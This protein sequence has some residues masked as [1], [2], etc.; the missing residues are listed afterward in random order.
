MAITFV[1]SN[2]QDSAGALSLTFTIPAGATTDDFMVAFVKQSENTGQQTWDDDGGGGNGWT[3]EAYNRTTGGRDQETAVYWKVHTG[4]ESNPTFTWNTSGTTEPMSGSLLVYRGVDP[5]IPISDLGFREAQNDANPPNPSANISYINTAVVCFHAATHDDISAVAA[6][7]GFNLRTQVWAGTSNDHRNHFTADLLDIDTL[8]SYTPPDWQHT[9]LNTT[10]EYH[11][12]TL[13]LNE[14]QPIGVTSAPVNS[15]YG[16]SITIGGFGFEA[17]QGTGKVELWDDVTGTTKVAQTVTSWSD[18]SIDI[19][20]TQGALG[21]DNEFY[22]VVTNDTGDVSSPRAITLGLAPYSVIIS[23]VGD[24]PDHHWPLDGDY[25]D[26][27]STNDITVSPI[28][29]GGTFVSTQ[30]SEGTTQSWRCQN[31]RREAPN[32]NQINGQTEQNRL[33]GG[34]IRLQTIQKGLACIYEEGGGVNNIAFFSGLGNVLIAQQAD[35]GDDNVQAFSDFKLTEDRDYHILFRFS[36]TDVTKEF[37]LYIDGEKQAVTSGNP[38]TATDL[39]G[40]SG[41]ISFGGP[42]GNLEVA[43]TDVL[44]QSVEDCLYSNWYTW[45]E[46]VS[47]ADILDLF[48]RGAVPTVTI[49]SDTEANMQIALD[50]LTGIERPDAPLAIRVEEVSGGGSLALDADDIVFNDRCT[51]FVEWRGSGTLTWKNLNGSNLVSEKVYTSGGG[52]VDI[53]N[54]AILTLNGL[55]NDT[56][57]RVYEAGTTTEVAGQE[58]VT[59]GTFSTSVEVNSVDIVIHSLDFLYQKLEGVDTSSGDVTLPIQQRTDRQFLNP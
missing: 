10:P 28:N 43:G 20:L 39:D 37:R 31:S 57:V 14:I 19:T 6:P 18:T 55:E 24:G 8:G 59:T 47:D 34:W 27:V 32:S 36:Y 2:V 1:D 30:I 5:S 56:E 44:F 42:G 41:D 33:M 58:S 23:G 52:S 53:V 45:D 11:T 16:T 25:E 38:L 7:T 51:I 12:Y 50:A 26:K 35:T 40:H 13:A 29:G 22:L 17:T 48:R 4:T 9:V 46:S 49:A 15:T 3:R 54:P 21:N